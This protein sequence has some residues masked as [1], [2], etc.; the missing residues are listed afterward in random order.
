MSNGQ[1]HLTYLPLKISQSL[2]VG[3][4][5]LKPIRILI[6]A[7]GVLAVLAGCAT[8]QL[9]DE[10]LADVQEGRYEE[11]LKKLE[12]A[13]TS[14]PGNA[15]YRLDL[16]AKHEEA[17]RAL[18][19]AADRARSTGAFDEA[20]LSLPARDRHR[21]RATIAPCADSSSWSAD[22]GMARS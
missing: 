19:A 12:E 6:G 15:M 13:S 3:E 21:G 2:P 4:R 17:I 14:S 20:E 22:A 11:G 16:K 9:H 8:A 1:L 5:A 10:G 7:F 18:I